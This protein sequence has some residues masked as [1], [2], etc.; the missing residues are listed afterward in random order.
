MSNN[1]SRRS[2]M[3][4]AAALA[5]VS[6]LSGALSGCG[7]A[8]GGVSV[9][10]SRTG[11]FT[12]QE[13]LFSKTLTVSVRKVQNFEYYTNLLVELDVANGAGKAAVKMASAA[14]EGSEGYV[15][16][17][18]VQI[19]DEVSSVKAGLVPDG[20]QCDEVAP[21]KTGEAEVLIDTGIKGWAKL[22]LTLTLYNG[23]E[24]VGEPV[25]FTFR[26]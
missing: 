15:L 25:V 9:I 23:S 5:A 11:S 6:A 8:L 14:S 1:L 20:L 26:R 12:I 2:F 22:E 24:A 4:G 19:L 10:G 17:P 13:G 18:T 3:K 7:S 16:V 21:G